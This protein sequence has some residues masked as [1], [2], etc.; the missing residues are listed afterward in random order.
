MVSTLQQGRDAPD[1]LRQ[2]FATKCIIPKG[3]LDHVRD[4]VFLGRRHRIAPVNRH[5]GP[6]YI[7]DLPRPLEYKARPYV[8]KT[9]YN[10]VNKGD[11]DGLYDA[12]AS[13]DDDMVVA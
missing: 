13:S 12:D 9:C 3:A 2:E 1:H 11:R 10:N 6:H 5:M 8:C 4:T 7:L